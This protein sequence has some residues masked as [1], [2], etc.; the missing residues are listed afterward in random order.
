MLV[1]VYRLSDYTT[2]ECGQDIDIDHVGWIIQS[3]RALV[4]KRRVELSESPSDEYRSCLDALI[5][6]ADDTA[7]R[8]QDHLMRGGM[9]SHEATDL[10]LEVDKMQER[11]SELAGRLF[12]KYVG[13]WS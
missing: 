13:Q 2:Q 10:M 6:A 8:I 12:E 9:S 1:G 3:H 4:N 11:A 5:V 7:R